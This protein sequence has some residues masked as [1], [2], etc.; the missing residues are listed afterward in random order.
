VP[1]ILSLAS[2]HGDMRTPLLESV[3]ELEAAY[4]LPDAEA[5]RGD[6]LGFWKLL[7]TSDDEAALSGST[8]FGAAARRSVLGHYSVF[9]EPDNYEPKPT[10]QTVEVVA[11][12]RAGSAGVGTL[13][14][15]FYVGTLASTGKL[16][17]VED[18]IFREYDDVRQGDGA[19][20]GS[21]WAIAYL[22]AGLRIARTEEGAL[23][24]FGKMGGAAAQAEIDALRAAP[25]AIVEGEE[26]EQEDDDRPLW[27]RRLDA[28]NPSFDRFGPP[29]E[30]DIP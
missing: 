21:R 2:L 5:I 1:R 12:N 23:M 27:Q 17:V 18:Y 13:R 3:A 7:L 20:H 6:L 4:T 26:E 30:S 24:I 10:L 16:G 14:G 25:V 8:G 15:D 19:A 9:T 29:G 11:D 22:D 28:E